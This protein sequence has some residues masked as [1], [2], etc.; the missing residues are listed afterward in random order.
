MRE[1]RPERVAPLRVLYVER[2]F[3]HVT[4][5]AADRDASERFYD[6][7]LASLGVE[8][9]YR[10]GA[11]SEWQDFSVAGAEA[12][13]PPTRRLHVAFVAPVAR[14]GGRV[15]AGRHRRRPRRRRAARPAAAVPGRLLRRLPARPRRQQRRGGASR[16]TAPGRRHRPPVDPGRRP[17]GG[18]ALLRDDRRARRPSPAPRRP[19]AR[20]V[21]GERQRL[22]LARAGDADREPAYG[23]RHRRR[24]RREAL[25]PRRR[26]RPAS[27]TTARR[28]SARCITPVTTP[29]TSR[30]RTATTS[31]S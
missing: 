9:S 19:R 29:P 27:A 1:A 11:F 25:P 3:D 5:R 12:T 2:V 24:R 4:I 17:G 26:P 30:T 18:E 22:V 23:V 6:T 28:A 21:R 16:P 15:L 7:V 13:Q 20:A 14:A 8:K 10:T 31:R